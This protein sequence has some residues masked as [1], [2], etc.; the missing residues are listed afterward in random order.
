M[1]VICNMNLF[2]AVALVPDE[3]SATL[4]SHFMQHVSMNLVFVIIFFLNNRTLFKGD[5][6]TMC[7]AL[8]LT[9]DNLVK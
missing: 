7:Y 3:T 4:A 1:N 5:L 2:V 9:C 8:C 6:I